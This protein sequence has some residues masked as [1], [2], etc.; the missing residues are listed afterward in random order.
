MSQYQYLEDDTCVC[1]GGQFLTTCYV[2]NGSMRQPYVALPIHPE[3]KW[4]LT[5]Q[6]QLRHLWRVEGCRLRRVLGSRGPVCG[7]WKLTTFQ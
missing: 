2:C 6:R 5:L 3:F 4:T 1:V 7:P